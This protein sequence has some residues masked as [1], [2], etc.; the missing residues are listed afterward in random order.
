VVTAL[1]SYHTTIIIEMPALATM[2]LN[3]RDFGI[4]VQIGC[5]VYSRVFVVFDC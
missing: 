5:V 4:L 1:V 2:M 3:S